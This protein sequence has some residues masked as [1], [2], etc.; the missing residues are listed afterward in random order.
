MIPVHFGQRDRPLFGVYDPAPPPR[1]RSAVLILN[2]GGWELIRAHRSLRTLAQQLQRAGM[3]VMRFDYRGTG[4]SWGGIDDVDSLHDWTED[5]DEAIEELT[6][7]AGVDRV[8]LVGLRMGASL[9][10][11]RGA[12]C[13]VALP[14]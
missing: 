13:E 10:G 3:D 12:R 8:S 11:S 6:G 2:P 1:K 5:V 7:L 9:D 14:S 4:D